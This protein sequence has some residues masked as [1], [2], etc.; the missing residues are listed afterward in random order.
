MERR[1][2][3]LDTWKGEPVLATLLGG[4]DLT[5]E[6]ISRAFQ[7]PTF[8]IQ[9]LPKAQTAVHELVEYDQLG[10]IL[11][12]R[13]KGAPRFFVPWGAVLSIQGAEPD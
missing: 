3:L 7:D 1:N 10:V 5:L 12:R 4:A 13:E 6:E 9:D 8:G 2:H 11:R